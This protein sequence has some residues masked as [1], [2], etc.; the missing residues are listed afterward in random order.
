[1]YVPYNRASKYMKQTWQKQREKTLLNTSWNILK[2]S[3]F[4]NRQ[5]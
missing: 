3:I 1:M 2:H 4:N 5:N